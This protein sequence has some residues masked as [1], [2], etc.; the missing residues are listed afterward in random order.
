VTI[1]K[2]ANT[3]QK[4]VGILAAELPEVFDLKDL[5]GDWDDEW[6][7]VPV[8]E[9]DE[10]H[11]GQESDVNPLFELYQ[12][13]LDSPNR[14]SHLDRLPADVS[15]GFPGSLR[16]EPPALLYPPPDAYAFYLPFHY[17]YPT[18][19]GIYLLHEGVLGLAQ[20]LETLSGCNKLDRW[21]YAEAARIF[22]FGHEQF[23]HEVESF[24]TRLE[25]THR[26]PL[27]RLGFVAEYQRTYGTDECLEEALANAHGVRRVL[28]AFEH[29]QVNE[30]LEVAFAG[31]IAG[32]GPGY[33]RG[34]EFVATP[35]FERGRNQL[36]EL[37]HKASLPNTKSTGSILWKSYPRA[38]HPF[39]TRNGRVNFL[40]HRDTAIDK[41]LPL[42]GRFFRYKD[43]VKQ[44][45]KVARCT[46]IGIKG[47]HVQFRA[48]NGGK[49]TVPRHPGDI[50][51]KTLNS[52]VHQTGLGMNV[53][54]FMNAEPARV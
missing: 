21:E 49:V 53:R 15:G 8:D 24:G 12:T 54:E 5:P 50:N 48:P 25:V 43:V 20:I 16:R 45:E 40:I 44:V 46:F 17:F 52:I 2:R 51:I 39:R 28:K 41:R 10:R 37:Y 7:F 38:F 34:F 11:A 14:V 36:A 18:W 30:I 3:D 1:T 32:C 6:V 29:P 26:D 42:L 27:Y 19:W 31:Y 35:K 22:L 9:P 4:E 13:E 47:S 23:H 33:R